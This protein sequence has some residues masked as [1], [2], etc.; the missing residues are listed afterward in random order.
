MSKKIT[1]DEAEDLLFEKHQKNIKLLEYSTMKE[2]AKFECLICGHVWNS[3]AF[4]VLRTGQGC[5]ECNKIKMSLLFTKDIEEVKTKI[6][7]IHGGNII[8]LDYKRV[9]EPANFECNICG[10]KWKT[11]PNNIIN[12]N[13]G[14]PNCAKTIRGNKKRNSFEKVLNYIESIGAKYISGEYKTVRT[15]LE[16]EFKCGHKTFIDYGHLVSG[17]RCKICAIEKGRSD[18]VKPVGELMEI[19]HNNNLEFVSFPNEYKNQNSKIRFSCVFGHITETRVTCLILYH[20]CK[21]CSKI[22]SNLF[23]RGENSRNWKG[24]ISKLANLLKGEILEWRKKSMELCNYQCVFTGSKDF[25][26]HHLYGF[27]MIV[28]ECLNNLSLSGKRLFDFT[29]EDILNIIIELKKLHEYYPTGICLRKDLHV[30]YH[31]KFGR[32]QILPEYFEQFKKMII[33]GEI[34]IPEIVK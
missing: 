22:K 9:G 17:S 32:K 12:L 6:K 31:Q 23:Y 24:G 27:T 26:I 2:T 15:K 30:L 14:C 13:N 19:L 4:N 29:S 7:Q 20:T 1:L 21:E 18:K 28:K 33:S 8:M 10:H 25:E 34:E 16:I 3:M 11:K 5:S